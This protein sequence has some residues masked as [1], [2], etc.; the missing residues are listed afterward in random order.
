MQDSEAVGSTD[1]AHVGSRE[2]VRSR[3]EV[4]PPGREWAEHAAA[5]ELIDWLYSVVRQRAKST[6]L[7][8][9]ERDEIA[10]DAMTPL[11]RGL[12]RSRE[13]YARAD[14]PAA[15]LE[16]VAARA[17][18]GSAHR[19]RMSGLGGVPANGRHWRATY[20]RPVRGDAAH[21]IFRTLPESTFAPSQA[22]DDAAGRI[23]RWVLANVGVDLSPDAVN[24][25]VYVLDRLV[26]GVSR[27]VLL[28]GAHSGLGADPAMG[29]LGFT[30]PAA[31][32]FGTWLL[33]RDD[34]EH[35]APS[36]IDMALGDELADGR[37][38]KRWRRTAVR[39]GFA[40]VAEPGAP[41][42]VTIGG[43]GPEGA[44]RSA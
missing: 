17:V 27:P 5:N 8:P 26:S 37:S 25:L 18:G 40:A 13:C 11:V 43:S 39:Y 6:F 29:H 23:A 38:A 34:P 15:V 16:R 22:V 2:W 9:D 21:R 41:Q 33:G 42:L 28:R 14:N 20:P 7:G 35:N 4:L 3:L 24:A 31:S 10:Q 44:R 1:V 19:L 36:V 12:Q 30:A 32:A